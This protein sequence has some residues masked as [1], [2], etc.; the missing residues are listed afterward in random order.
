[1][2]AETELQPAVVFS[3]LVPSLAGA[4][5][6]SSRR[7]RPLCSR[8]VPSSTP[9]SLALPPLHVCELG[10]TAQGR[11]G[12]QFGAPAWSGV[13]PHPSVANC[14]PLCRRRG[15]VVSLR[16]PVLPGALSFSN[17]SGLGLEIGGPERRPTERRH[18][19]RS[20]P[21]GL[22]A[23]SAAVISE[24]MARRRRSGLGPERAAVPCASTCRLFAGSTR[25]R[26]PSSFL[27]HPKI[28]SPRGDTYSVREDVRRPALRARHRSQGLPVF[29]SEALQRERKRAESR[30]MPISH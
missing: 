18:Q 19:A 25:R 23:A 17:R 4:S 20:F 22:A 24:S 11:R 10:A 16:Y 28:A 29:P 8:G 7:C 27:G 21:L 15:P 3:D 2:T 1:M 30:A 12:R 26:S 6:R 14:C 9:P 5:R 13:F